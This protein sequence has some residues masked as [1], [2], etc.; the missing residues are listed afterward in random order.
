MWNVWCVAMTLAERRQTGT[1][2]SCNTT[3]K[4]PRHGNWTCNLLR[5]V[6][7]ALKI[8][9]STNNVGDGM[10]QNRCGCL[11][12]LPS[13]L[14][15]LLSDDDNLMIS[16]TFSHSDVKPCTLHLLRSQIL[17]PSLSPQPSA[18]IPH[19]SPTRLLASC[20]PTAAVPPSI[21]PPGSHQVFLLCVRLER[22]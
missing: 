17:L 7:I 14:N 4:S 9:F 21:P 16:E 12:V 8:T 3:H 13:K 1:G 2:R 10:Q 19:P 20:L 5:C 15:R 22:A 18:L 6:V 11:G